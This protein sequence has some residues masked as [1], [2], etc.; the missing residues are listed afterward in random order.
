MVVRRFLNVVVVFAKSP[1]DHMEQV[2]RVLWLLYKE[3]VTLKLK[4]RKCFAEAM[5]YLGHAI[6]PVRVDLVE[7]MTSELAKLGNP[8]KQTELCFFLG[9]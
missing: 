6:R 8:I 9:L 7:H 2:Q 3:R 5:Y 1:T 4:R